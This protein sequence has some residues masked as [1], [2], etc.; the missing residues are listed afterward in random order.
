MPDFS[1]QIVADAPDDRG[2]RIILADNGLP[3]HPEPHVRLCVE[4]RQ[5]TVN[6]KLPRAE[7]HDGRPVL[8]GPGS[9]GAEQQI[10]VSLNTRRHAATREHDRVP[11]AG[12]HR[13]PRRLE[14]FKELLSDFEIAFVTGYANHW[15]T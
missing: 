7:L 11:A 5:R 6:G 12:S 8:C 9:V 4:D 14:E 2:A 15:V 13:L 10:D 3:A 1:E